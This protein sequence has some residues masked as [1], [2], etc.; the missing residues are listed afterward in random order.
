MGGRAEFAFNLTLT[1][2]L[3]VQDYLVELLTGRPEAKDVRAFGL[4]ATMRRRFDE[5]SAEYTR[6]LRRHVRR[7]MTYNALGMVLTGVVGIADMA[8]LL[9]LVE[10]G[11]VDVAEA[12]AAAIAVVLLGSRLAMVASGIGALYES[13]LFL[14]DLDTF[15]RREV[16]VEAS[17]E[18]APRFSGLRVRDVSF[19]YPAGDPARP[20]LRGVDLDVRPG[21]VVALVGANGSGK[22]TLAKIVAGLY[23]PTSGSILHRGDG[24]APPAGA[25]ARAGRLPVPGLHALRPQ[26]ARQRRPRRARPCRTTMAAV[27]EAARRAGADDFLATLPDGYDTLL[28]VRFGGHD[29][30]GGQWQRVALARAVMRGAPFI[31]LDEPTSAMD[32]AAEAALFDRL[33]EVMT[34]RAVLIVSHR[35]STVRERRPDLRP[36][37]RPDGRERGPRGP[38]GAGR[39]V[40]PDVPAAG[41]GL[42]R[43][44]GHRTARHLARLTPGRPP[45]WSYRA[46][47]RRVV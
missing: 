3:R 7:R 17:P 8:L 9:V 31:V 19:A 42:R 14:D 32:A 33:R 36:G 18:V 44:G 40:R 39:A 6:A 5:V 28:S 12:S 47:G 34:G 26:R 27:R 23:A 43:H 15:L 4:A 37:R 29:L 2:L 1:P 13:A 30:S 21:E 35:F 24:G 10:Q 45:G 38:D 11:S 25:A 46:L 20:A 16:G 41:R 22:T